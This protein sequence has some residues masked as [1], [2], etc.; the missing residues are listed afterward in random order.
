MNQFGLILKHARN[1]GFEE[2]P[3][4]KYMRGLLESICQQEKITVDY[5]FDWCK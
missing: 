3:N 2:E 1:L 5:K 4:Y